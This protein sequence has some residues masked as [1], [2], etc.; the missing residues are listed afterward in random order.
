MVR[1]CTPGPAGRLSPGER[2]IRVLTLALPITNDLA[3]L[4]N[5]ASAPAMANLLSKMGAGRARK[6]AAHT[7]AGPDR[8]QLFRRYRPG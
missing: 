6:R 2:R 4:Y 3:V 8:I 5:A 7:R 1:T